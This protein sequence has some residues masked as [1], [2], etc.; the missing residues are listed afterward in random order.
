MQKANLQVNC[1]FEFVNCRLQFIKCKLQ[2][3][4]YKLQTTI[5]KLQTKEYSFTFYDKG[6]DPWSYKRSPF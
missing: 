5:Y 2:I 4:I 6:V 3:T 1:Q